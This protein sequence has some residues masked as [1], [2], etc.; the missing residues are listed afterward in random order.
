VRSVESLKRKIKSVGESCRK[1]SIKT[2][3]YPVR[4]T[5]EAPQGQLQIMWVLDGR[6]LNRCSKFSQK[7]K[8][9]ITRS[10][11]LVESDAQRRYYLKREQLEIC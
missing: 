11:W 7:R 5:R 10:Y 6:L 9:W 1:C 2:R 3:L 8:M 4:K